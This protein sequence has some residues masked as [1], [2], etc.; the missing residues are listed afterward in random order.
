M[1]F[2]G[3]EVM[4]AWLYGLGFM[5]KIKMST[6]TNVFFVIQ[7]KWM[8]NSDENMFHN[9]QNKNLARGRKVRTSSQNGRLENTYIV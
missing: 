2:K 3:P 7:T 6:F 4:N 5:L 1:N 8:I 9:S